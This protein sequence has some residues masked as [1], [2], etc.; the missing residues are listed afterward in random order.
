[1]LKPIFSKRLISTLNQ[2]QKAKDTNKLVVFAGAGISKGSGVPLWGELAEEIKKKIEDPGDNYSNYDPL[3]LAELLYNELGTKLYND[4]IREKLCY[5]QTSYNELHELILNLNP[6]HIITTNYDNHFE[7]VIDKYGLNYSIV[8]KDEDL[9]YADYPNMLIKM[10]G[11]FDELNMVLKEDDYLNYSNNFTLIEGFIKGLFTTH[12]V[13]F[14]GYSFSDFDLKVILT[15]LRRILGRHISPSYIF[16]PDSKPSKELK[17][18]DQKGILSI[19]NDLLSFIEV[20]NLESKGS[21][22][23]TTNIDKAKGHISPWKQILAKNKE[24]N[25]FD[26]QSETAAFLR[27]MVDY[28][29]FNFEC[30]HYSIF[31]KINKSIDRYSILATFPKEIICQIYPLNIDTYSASVIKDTLYINS[32]EFK[33]FWSSILKENEIINSRGKFKYLIC[34]SYDEFKGC[35][36]S[37]HFEAAMIREV[38]NCLYNLNRCGLSRININNSEFELIFYNTEAISSLEKNKNNWFPLYMTLDLYELF[39]QIKNENLGVGIDVSSKVKIQELV[40]NVHILKLLNFDKEAEILSNQIS[41]LLKKRKDFFSYFIIQLL[42]TEILNNDLSNKQNNSIISIKGSRKVDIDKLCEFL[43]VDADTRTVMRSL[44]RLSF[45]EELMDTLIF[46]KKYLN[47]SKR[48]YSNTNLLDHEE[49]SDSFVLSLVQNIQSLFNLNNISYIGQAY[50][51][52]ILVYVLEIYFLMSKSIDKNFKINKG[53]VLVGAIYPIVKHMRTD[54]LLKLIVENNVT[55]FEEIDR[56]SIRYLLRVIDNMIKIIKSTDYEEIVNKFG[57]EK[58]YM[59]IN[60]AILILTLTDL[61]ET[62]IK[63]LLKHLSYLNELE[64]K[65]TFLS[66]EII[67]NFILKQNIV[68]QDKST[69]S[70]TDAS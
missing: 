54:D 39:K 24:I 70:K 58:I 51:N 35:L 12:T 66:I 57:E 34:S 22:L 13:L 49:I 16:F 25:S 64:N 11:D 19:T 2:I 45:I 52:T 63:S 68:L 23:T 42:R 7:Q 40:E 6:A 47:D 3:K 5:R 38:Y 69:S 4:F 50:F 65:S 33:N 62:N 28:N 61:S 48:V 46:F 29:D 32:S 26:H 60:N 27:F 17:Y 37:G 14:L 44:K 18:L 31:S 55:S 1:M 59:L 56:K 20:E 10:H 15:N 36:E 8:S 9:S 30:E 53:L 41:V 43:P 67:D 21:R